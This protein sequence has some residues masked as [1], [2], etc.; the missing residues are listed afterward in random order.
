VGR[1]GRPRSQ[2]AASA[3]IICLKLRLY[4]G[5]DDDLIAFFARAPSGL[6]AATAKRVLREGMCLPDVEVR[7]DDF[8]A[9]LDEL[10]D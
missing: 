10:V 1:R 5:E 9:A 8:V 2:R 6:L 4:P 7:G 3:R